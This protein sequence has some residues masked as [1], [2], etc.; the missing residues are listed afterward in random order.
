[1]QWIKLGATASAL[2]NR[3]AVQEYISKQTPQRTQQRKCV[4]IQKSLLFKKRFEVYCVE[5][6]I[7]FTQ[8]SFK[9]KVTFKS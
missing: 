9:F 2:E 3:Q 1:M 6:S 4:L 7:P 5:P 8:E